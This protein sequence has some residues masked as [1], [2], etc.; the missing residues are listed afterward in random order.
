MEIDRLL[1]LIKSDGED[2]RNHFSF[3][4]KNFTGLFWCFSNLQGENSYTQY[5]FQLWVQSD[6]IV[7]GIT[8]VKRHC[9]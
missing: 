7:C 4:I 2:A 9:W 3:P 1:N 5:E 8:Y 6:H